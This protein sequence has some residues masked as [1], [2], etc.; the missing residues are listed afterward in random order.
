MLIFSRCLIAY[1][2]AATELK[3]TMTK[4]VSCPVEEPTTCPDCRP[5]IDVDMVDKL[6]NST[7]ILAQIRASSESCGSYL[8]TTHFN[9]PKHPL[10][11]ADYGINRECTCPEFDTGYAII[12]SD[13]SEAV[14][15]SFGRGTYILPATPTNAQE[16]NAFINMCDA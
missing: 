16:V 6:C 13:K 7:V 10:N 4:S 3:S 8:T 9:K 2:Q 14:E 11:W 1:K 15:G 12:V 5:R